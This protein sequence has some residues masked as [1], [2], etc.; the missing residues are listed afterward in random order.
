MRCGCLDYDLTQGDDYITV[1]EYMKLGS[2]LL[3]GHDEDTK[4]TVVKMI[5]DS[6]T[7]PGDHLQVICKLGVGLERWIHD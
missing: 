5:C 1:L 2:D 4:R 7:N 3:E 6:N